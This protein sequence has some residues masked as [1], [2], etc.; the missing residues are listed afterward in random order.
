MNQKSSFWILC[1]E[2]KFSKSSDLISGINLHWT[3]PR[4]SPSAQ[5]CWKNFWEI[6]AEHVLFLW[7]FPVTMDKSYLA[8]STRLN[9]SPKLSDFGNFGFPKFKLVSPSNLPIKLGFKLRLLKLVLAAVPRLSWNAPCARGL[10]FSYLLRL[11][12]NAQKETLPTMLGSE[13]SLNFIFFFFS[14]LKHGPQKLTQW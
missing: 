8:R 4:A 2:S 9:N 13:R 7:C 1:F 10:E 14:L 3:L 11:W 12:I 5:C 6:E